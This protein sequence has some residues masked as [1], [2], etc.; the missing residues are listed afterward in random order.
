MKRTLSRLLSCALLCGVLCGLLPVRADAAGRFSDVPSGSWAAKSIERAVDLG[1]FQGKSATRFGMGEG[2]T[3]SAFAVVL[4]RLFDWELEK[5]AEGSFADN[6]NPDAWYYAAVE[7]AYRQGAIPGQSEYFRPRD[8]IAREEMAVMLVRAL[9]Y[10][11]IAGLTQ[12]LPMPFRDVTTNAGYIAMAHELGIINGVS[13]TAFSPDTPATREQVAVMLVR[14]YD[15]YYSAAPSLCGLVRES[16]ELPELSAYTAL[17][18]DGVQLARGRVYPGA[19]S[20]QQ[21]EALRQEIQGAGG[22]ALLAVSGSAAALDSGAA[23]AAA[24][25]TARVTDEGWDGVL[26]DLPGLKEA[27]RAGLTALVQALDK[28]LGKKTLYV[29]AEAP[30]WQEERAG[31]YDY[32]ALAKSADRLILRAA[33]YEKRS[34]SFPT[35]PLEPLEEL[36]YAL[37]ELKGT[38]RGDKLSLWI[39]TTGRQWTGGS[40]AGSCT[41]QE[42]AQLLE[43]SRTEDYYSARYEAAY[44]INSASGGQKV[45][46]YQDGRSAAARAQL[47]SFFNVSSFFLSDVQSVAAYPQGSM[48]DGL[49]G[50]L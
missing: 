24:L 45:V 36:Y 10:T 13:D 16:G 2:M 29:T 1:L 20:G 7:T 22:K 19:L 50:R 43:S 23:E 42:I 40:S 12:Q 6:Q 9:G 32:A 41:A 11:T 8:A 46:W 4:C 44:L 31:G 5:P 27:E 25:L 30:A 28:A 34:G 38:V 48:T 39:T 15:K 37:A 18:V 35:A 49:L 3:R 47:A 33:S 26:L 14:V 21:M 17:A